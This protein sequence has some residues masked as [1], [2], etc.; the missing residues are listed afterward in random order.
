MS[1]QLSVSLSMLYRL[2]H[3]TL[4]ALMKLS[5]LII[6][7]PPCDVGAYILSFCIQ[8]FVLPSI[9]MTKLFIMVCSSVIMCSVGVSTVLM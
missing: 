4:I 8:F 5:S 7:K 1:A 3:D 6:P 2:I 9:P